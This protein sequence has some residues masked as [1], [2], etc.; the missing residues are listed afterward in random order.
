MP[1]PPKPE[2]QEEKAC[3]KKPYIAQ[4]CPFNV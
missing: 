3:M 4:R 1:K 2:T